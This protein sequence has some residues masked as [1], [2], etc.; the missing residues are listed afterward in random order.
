MYLIRTLETLADSKSENI[1]KGKK[2]VA[3]YKYTFIQLS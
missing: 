3:Y 2:D 1:I